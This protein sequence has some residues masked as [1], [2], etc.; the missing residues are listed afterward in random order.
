M[1]MS[2]FSFTSIKQALQACENCLQAG[3]LLVITIKKNN[4]DFS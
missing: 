4:K 2:V 3:F 1:Y